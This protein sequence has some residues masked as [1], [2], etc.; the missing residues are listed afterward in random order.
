MRVYE[1]TFRLHKRIRAKFDVLSVEMA[2]QIFG[3]ARG[4][5]NAIADRPALQKVS[6]DVE[7]WQRTQNPLDLCNSSRMTDVI[8][9]QCLRVSPNHAIHRP[10]NHSE[11]FGVFPFHDLRTLFLGHSH[12]RV[13]CISSSKAGHQHLPFGSMVSKEGGIPKGANGM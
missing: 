3:H 13:V 9:R 7:V 6:C 12:K 8:L 5:V 2:M 4:N 11:D 10:A 1:S